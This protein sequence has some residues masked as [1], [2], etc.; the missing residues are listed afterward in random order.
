M[1]SCNEP[2]L[3]LVTQFSLDNATIPP[4]YNRLERFENT[5]RD[6]DELF[7]ASDDFKKQAQNAESKPSCLQEKGKA[8][9]KII[10]S[11]VRSK[12]RN[13]VSKF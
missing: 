8:L 5:T 2:L 11:L 9:E 10:K 4:H 3:L 6:R 7:R 12:Q 13:K 1:K